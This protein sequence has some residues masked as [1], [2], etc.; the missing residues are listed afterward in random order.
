MNI[1]RIIGSLRNFLLA[2]GVAVAIGQV[3]ARATLVDVTT[4]GNLLALLPA[5][6]LASSSNNTSFGAGLSQIDDNFVNTVNQD[7]GLIFADSDTD[8]RVAITG[9]NSKI[10]DIRFFT[11]PIDPIRFPPTL[12]IYSSDSS[13]TSL[14]SSS[15]T[16]LVTT[17]ALNPAAF[18]AVPGSTAAYIDIYVNAPV[19]TQSLFLDLGSAAGIGDRIS[20]LQ[21]YAT[22]PEPSSLWL[23]ATGGF[24][25]FGMW[26]FGKFRRCLQ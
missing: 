24:I 7:N 22:A 23:I 1:E 16:P 20:E 3:P 19:G 9:F 21:V 8:Q 25:L 4:P 2:V 10:S 14:N 26:R 18:N 13:T 11:S 5:S 17:F 6:D 15:Y 12:T